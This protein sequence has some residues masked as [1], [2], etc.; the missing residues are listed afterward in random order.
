M[1]FEKVFIA[2]SVS[3]ADLKLISLHMMS[4]LDFYLILGCALKDQ[5]ASH[6][7]SILH[8][9]SYRQGMDSTELLI[10]QRSL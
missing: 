8:L 2:H 4:E 7:I 10:F 6:F 1:K 3:L 9:Q 5:A